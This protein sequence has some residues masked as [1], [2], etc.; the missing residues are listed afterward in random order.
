MFE[1]VA[2]NEKNRQKSDG[3]FGKWTFLKCPKCK[4][5]SG[6]FPKKRKKVILQENALISEK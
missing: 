2:K 1:N 4:T 3:T 5:R 6:L